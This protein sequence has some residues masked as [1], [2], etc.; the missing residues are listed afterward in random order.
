MN[1][2]RFYTSAERLTNEINSSHES[3]R[4]RFLLSMSVGGSTSMVE[5]LTENG[6][7]MG[8]LSIYYYEKALE[9][10]RLKMA[11][12]LLSNRGFSSLETSIRHIEHMAPN[13]RKLLN[14]PSKS[15]TFC[16][17]LARALE[18]LGPLQ[19]LDD[20][21]AI[22]LSLVMI[23]QDALL[24]SNVQLSD[25]S[26]SS[27]NAYTCNAVVRLLLE[28]GLFR[29]S[30]LPAYYWSRLLFVNNRAFYESPL[31]LAIFVRNAYAVRLLLQNG[32][33]ADEVY[34]YQV[35]GLPCMEYEGSPLTY[36]TWLGF[37]DAVT[38]LL[39]AGADVTKKGSLGQT[40]PE[41][42]K[43]CVS[44]LDAI[45]PVG[46]CRCDGFER[47]KEE[48]FSRHEIA[49]V[50]FANLETRHGMNYENFI[51]A[52]QRDHIEDLALKLAGRSITCFDQARNELIACRSSL[53]GPSLLGESCISRRCRQRNFVFHLGWCLAIY[54]LVSLLGLSLRVGKLRK[55]PF[56]PSAIMGETVRSV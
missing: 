19:K 28:A 18:P 34:Y 23:F 43:T 29:D 3:L 27:S 53:D 24:E 44:F 32:Y 17:I 37:A 22:F 38:I 10:G 35:G 1:A 20:K 11:Y 55:K 40:A 9:R 6:L 51:C 46:C 12:L 15:K 52:T 26:R 45:L 13:F 2:L 8:D 50:I 30:K 39:E 7:S 49:T 31:T 33:D 42:A 25:G 16:R 5:A 41:M 21:H 48:K 56:A 36:A 54:A 14:D 47:I 4:H